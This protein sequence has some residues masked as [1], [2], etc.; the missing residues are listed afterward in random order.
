MKTSAPKNVTWWVCLVLGVLGVLANIASIPV[1][2]AVLGFW[3]VVI[4]LAV[5]LI[6]T[7]TKGL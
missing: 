5:L 2:T 3:L 6:A 4:G 1:I 7:I